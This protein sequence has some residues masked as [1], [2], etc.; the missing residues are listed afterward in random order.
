MSTTEG[1]TRPV[2]PEKSLQS[3]LLS[4]LE[5]LRR[6][7]LERNN[8]ATTP[9]DA[10]KPTVERIERKVGDVSEK[11]VVGQVPTSIAS[12]QYQWDEQPDFFIPA[13]H[14]STTRDS[15]SIMDIAIFRLSKKNQ[16]V[17]EVIRYELL[18]GHVEVS[19]GA[20]GMATVWDYDIVLMMVSHLNQAMNRYRD[21]AGDKPGKI[22]RPHASEI[23]KFTRRGN[24]SRQAQEIEAALDRLQ[25]TRI[26][27]VRMKADLRTTEA[28]GLITRYRV[29]SRTSTNKID[30]VEIEV[31]EWIYH[32]I[33]NCKSPSVM[34]VHPDY[35]LI[36]KGIGRFVY[37]LARLRAGKTVATWSFKKIYE[38]SGSSGAAERFF[39]HLRDIIKSDCLPEYTLE[40]RTGNNRS[41]MLVMKKR[42]HPLLP[43]S[44]PNRR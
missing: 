32:E 21:G 30:S 13:L 8:I 28:E 12:E 5:T 36:T 27:T 17:G 26:K 14:V 9:K 10:Q 1:F 2:T 33:V 20:F 23:L 18:D 7:S 4:R 34:T 44:S 42:S 25:T 3:P 43:R 11:S 39:Q 38:H 29:L 41:P 15:R 16:R 6:R 22:F 31:P 19:S 24:G 40:E 35:F 37:R